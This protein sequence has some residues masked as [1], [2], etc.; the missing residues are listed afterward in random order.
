[1]SA[2]IVPLPRIIKTILN[3][4]IIN[5][6]DEI[7]C[8][9]AYKELLKHGTIKTVKASPRD[10]KNTGSYRLPWY[11]DEV[12]KWI[13]GNSILVKNSPIKL[14]IDKITKPIYIFIIYNRRNK[15][16]YVV[17][18]CKRLVSLYK[19]TKLL[20]TGKVYLIYFSTSKMEK[21]FPCEAWANV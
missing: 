5:I 8:L 15:K 18:G 3:I 19:N 9:S 12:E 4:N 17:D 1:M 7:I 11:K 20:E 6:L 16:Y 10:I 2:L 13:V 14:K 21:L